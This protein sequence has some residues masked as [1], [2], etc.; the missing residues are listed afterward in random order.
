[1]LVDRTPKR[2]ALF[3][4]KVNR[5]PGEDT[6]WP[7]IGAKNEG[8]YGWI[9]VY[10]DR[11]QHFFLAHKVSYEWEFGEISQGQIV[12][13]RCD[14]PP[15]VRPSH[16]LSGT[17][18]DNMTDMVER[19]RHVGT[20]EINVETVIRIRVRRSAGESA[21][22]LGAEYG[23][24]PQ[25]VSNICT[26]VYWPDAGGPLTRRFEIDDE[27]IL[28]VLRDLSTMTQSACAARRGISKAAVQQIASGKRKARN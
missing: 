8:G 28:D 15:C 18:Q 27:M 5:V 17:H 7:W 16:L 11:K 3:W 22:I 10:I 6:C 21:K 4:A 19:K 23:L 14:N 1:M 13:H 2:D 24:S 26:G 20:R 25:H 12:R 9:T